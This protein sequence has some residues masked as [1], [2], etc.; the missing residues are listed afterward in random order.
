MAS[1]INWNH[2]IDAWQAK[3]AFAG[4]LLPPAGLGH[5]LLFGPAVGASGL[6]AAPAGCSRVGAGE[7]RAK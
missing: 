6:R 5:V 2:H 7:D 1:R 3:R 4:G